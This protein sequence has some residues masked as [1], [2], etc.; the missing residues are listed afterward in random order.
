MLA[1]L[2]VGMVAS[3]GQQVGQDPERAFAFGDTNLDNR[4][5]LEELRDLFT[6][7]ARLKN[8]A[9][10]KANVPVEP[11]FRRLDTN[12]DGFLSIAEYRKITQ[13]RP[14]GMGGGMGPFAKLNPAARKPEMPKTEVT[15]SKTAN[16][17]V[18][19]PITAEQ[20]K[21][22]ETKIRPVLM[23]KC[24][25]CHSATSKKLK[26][27]L[28]VDSR[29][30]L[31][32]GGDTG[33]AI[34]PGDLEE[35]L[36][37]K[38]IAF[39][40]ESLQMPP[41]AK[42][43][44]DVIQDFQTWVKMG[45]PDPRTS[46]PKATTSKS[47]IASKSDKA[48]D[49]QSFWAFQPLKKSPAPSIQEKAWPKSDIDRY[50]LSSLEA[51]GLKPVGDA[52]RQTLIRRATFDLTGLPPTPKEVA[53]FLS[54][55]SSDAFAKVVDR[56]LA[57]PRFG[58]RWG[59]H[60]LDVA[61]YAESSGKANM[62]YSN[63]WRYRDWV[64]A[65]FNNDKPYRQFVAEQIAGDL[66]P[67]K[68][69]REKAQ[70]TIATGF[71]AIG[72]KT[73]NTQNR[74]QF[75]LDMADEQ[76]EA[77]SQ[78]FLGL[79][80][81][82]ARCHDHKFDP[83]SQRDYYAL[84]GI[85]QSSQTCYGT[86]PGVIQN[87][88]PSPLI[89][90][91]ASAKLASAMPKLNSPRLASIEKQ[92]ESLTK[93][94]DALTQEEN[95]TGK[96]IRTR[97]LLAIT[98]FRLFAYHADGTPR[99]YVMGV[100]E[101][102][103]P[104]DSP[105]YVRGELEHP[106]GTVPRGVLDLGP[107]TKA[108]QV[109]QGSGRKQLAEWMTSPTNPLT[110][111]VMANRVWLHL[112]GRGLVPSVDNFGAAGQGPSHPELLDSIT[113]AFRDNQ[114][115]IKGLIRQIML[116]RTYQLASTHDAKSFEVDPDN[117]LHWRM[118]PRRLEAEALRDAMLAISGRLLLEPPVGS[119]VAVAGE[120][121]VGPQRNFGAD[122]GDVHRSIYLPIVRDQVSESLTV[123][124][125]ADPSLVTGDRSTTSGPTQSLYLLNSGF[126]YRQAETT[127]KKLLDSPDR[128]A[129]IEQAYVNVLS[130]NPTPAET[131]RART[132]L[133]TFAESDNTSESEVRAWTAFCQ[134]L[135]AS[136]E[137]RYIN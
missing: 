78:A 54:D 44:D 27:G 73:H 62:I 36:L 49:P 110:Y 2:G 34:V 87:I 51:K 7:T 133:K 83:I 33:P 65:A 48:T 98:K 3:F 26:G 116:S 61:R 93:E 97:T 137:F 5:T 134:A 17:I 71:L 81:Q 107:R 35:S 114:G 69:D 113:I 105:L 92:V 130:R 50:I 112:F 41:K 47:S 20:T 28:L 84:S 40:D 42:L 15:K 94:R 46:S 118:S 77:T 68:D 63:A 13:L 72:S 39:K 38:A 70:H 135:L 89:E 109:N 120:G 67:A 45:A 131:D 122:N 102:F 16:V 10:K 136:A 6:S 4:L 56:L 103:E 117:I 9:A 124:D 64:I 86:L 125:F 58:E 79:T 18:G 8:A 119:I 123:F 121:L 31:L 128:E 59:R 82:C 37:I 80:I 85:F 30:G 127:A 21:F 90:I 95:F 55:G 53:D 111:R 1:V 76:I 52:D 11:L 19:T 32:R 106:E 60:W 101:R 22:F 99:T 29:E 24:A 126:V 75:V 132:F 12:A 88:N 96:G 14:G 57:S 104:I 129:R 25:E 91:P 115:S 100:R 43:S 74:K 23:T 66:L 108:I